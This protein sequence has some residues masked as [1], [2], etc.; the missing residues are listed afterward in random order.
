[1][2]S[3]IAKAVLASV[4]VAGVARAEGPPAA[5]AERPGV[6]PPPRPSTTFAAAQEAPAPAPQKAPAPADAPAPEPAPAPPGH[7]PGPD[8]VPAPCP[9]EG[10]DGEG[11]CLWAGVD[12]LFWWVRGGFLP[13][14]A[15]TAP[16]TTPTEATTLF[17]D[18]RYNGGVHSGVRAY[19]GAWL[20]SARTLGIE[21]NYFQVEAKATRFAASS[22]GEPVLA[23]PFTNSLGGPTA[24]L[25]AFPG[26]SAGSIAVD[27]TSSGLIGA[28]GLFRENLA[29]CPDYCLDLV[30]GYRYLRFADRLGIRTTVG[31]PG[32]VDPNNATVVVERWDAKNNIHAF[33]VGFAGE[34]RS[35][36]WV[37]SWLAK[38]AVGRNL[39]TVDTFASTTGVVGGVPVNF[40]NAGLLLQ[41]S[42]VGHIDH[43]RYVFIPEVNVRL[44]Y[45]IT[46]NVR[47]SLGY[48]FLSVNGIARPGE[49]VPVNIPQGSL[50][51]V[52][53][54]DLTSPRAKPT[55]TVL[56]AQ[57]IDLGLEIQF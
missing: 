19:A 46:P 28:G 43:E 52:V 2:N 51:P 21:G 38:G 20:D 8:G 41:Q 49:Q 25:V 18:R 30:A 44:A 6:L 12:Y 14:L 16:V 37:L 45:D 35:G 57:G 23:R 33:D 4:L 29:R 17:G 15:I 39:A 27:Y 36:P 9:D 31:A 54:S 26:V 1:M 56:W 13:P 32:V 53:P 55:T 34:F 42:D 24:E 48:T 40:T 3:R 11:P 5:P 47:A 22:P 10:C 50:P 7:G